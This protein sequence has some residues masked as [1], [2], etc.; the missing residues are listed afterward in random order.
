MCFYGLLITWETKIFKNP[1]NIAFHGKKQTNI[2]LVCCSVA[3][4][5]P[6]IDVKWT[7]KRNSMQKMILKTIQSVSMS[8]N[9][10][11][12][13]HILYLQHGIALSG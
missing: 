10:K 2:Y 11:I 7:I 12:E 4:S 13:K 3:K 6:L 8:I 1:F 9:R 5:Y